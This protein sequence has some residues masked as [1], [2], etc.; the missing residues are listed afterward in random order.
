MKLLRSFPIMV[1]ALVLL[2][3]VGLCAAQWSVKMLLVAAA[4]AVLSWYVTE[5]PR[6]R[7]LPKWVS[8]VLVVAAS[9]SVIVDLLMPPNDVLNVLGRFSIW[10]TLIKLYERRTA[11][12]HVHLMGLSLL[13]ILVGCLK[14]NDL[15][16]GV[17]LVAYAALGVYVLLLFQLYV[18]HEDAV[19]ARRSALPRSAGETVRWQGALGSPLGPTIGRRVVVQFRLLALVIGIIGVFVSVGIF[20][21]VPRSA[22][23]GMNGRPSWLP[24]AAR[25]AGFSD[26]IDLD[27]GT[28]VTDSRRVAFEMTLRDEAGRPVRRSDPVLLRGAVLEVYAN[29]R[30]RRA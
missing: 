11:R 5:G 6:G 19:T 7:T 18:A 26:E 20:G 28:R 21:L 9:I 17:V 2:G 30:W 1:V 13:L 12:D 24:G 14:T 25:T 23:H 4:L 27:A 8:N 15:L 16:F 22:G 29:G 10:L 3:I